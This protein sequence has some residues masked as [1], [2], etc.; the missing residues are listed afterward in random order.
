MEGAAFHKELK[1]GKPVG[2]SSRWAARKWVIEPLRAKLGLDR[3][4]TGLSG[5]APIS[6]ETQNFFASI[7]LP[8][9]EVY[10]L[11]ESTGIL[12]TTLPNYL[13]PGCVGVPIDGVSLKLADDGEILCRGPV[14]TQGYLYDEERTAMLWN[15]GWMHTG[16]LGRFDEEGN[17]VITG[18]KKDILIT[19]GGKK[20]AP[21]AIESRMNAL[22]FVAQSLVV[23]DARPYLTAFIAIDP[24]GAASMAKN[25]GIF[26]ASPKTLVDNE[27]FKDLAQREIDRIVN[28]ALARYETVKHVRL[29]PEPF[30]IAAGEITPT[31]KLRRNVVYERYSQEIEALYG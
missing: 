15:R 1:T 24:K 13:K 8:L 27:Q 19:A 21:Q 28:S 23:G 10:G 5:S 22:P 6:A 14:T 26:D 31:L 29:F 30:S 9:V 16:D 3:L 12:A 7:G 17:L 18:R 11:S 2:G 4:T 20:V 25:L